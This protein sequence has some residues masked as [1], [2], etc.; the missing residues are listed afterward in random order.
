MQFSS[1]FNQRNFW[2]IFLLWSIW[3]FMDD[4]QGSKR[5]RMNKKLTEWLPTNFWKLFSLS[6]N[7][8]ISTFSFELWPTSMA[9]YCCVP[10]ANLYLYSLPL[11][12]GVLCL[13]Q[14]YQKPQSF[15]RHRWD[16][17][18]PAIPFALPDQYHCTSPFPV[19]LLSYSFPQ[20][21]TITL[22]DR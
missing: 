20:C 7:S 4:I 10:E 18:T 9:K 12:K 22:M 19:P 17:P 3:I 6:C 8:Q 1:I 13:L 15:Q 2:N 16:H 14:K 11:K 21:I 5:K